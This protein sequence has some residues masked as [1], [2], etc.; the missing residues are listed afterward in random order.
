MD[1]TTVAVVSLVQGT[2]DKIVLRKPLRKPFVPHSSGFTH[3]VSDRSQEKLHH[4]A[5]STGLP[6]LKIEWQLPLRSA[7]LPSCYPVGI[8]AFVYHRPAHHIP[9]ITGILFP[10]A[11]PSSTV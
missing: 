2:K 7:R 4:W 9:S 1:Q 5:V 10:D 6:L 11:A 3:S 8:G